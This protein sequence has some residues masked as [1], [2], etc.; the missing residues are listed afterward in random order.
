[1]RLLPRLGDETHKDPSRTTSYGSTI[2]VASSKNVH[3]NN[4]YRDGD[5]DEETDTPFSFLAA[6]GSS[7]QKP[8]LER[9]DSN[10][11]HHSQLST[12]L[13]SV[14]FA[15]ETEI[16]TSNRGAAGSLVSVTQQQQ[17]IPLVGGATVLSEVINITKNLLGAGVLSLSG[18][19]ALFTDQSLTAVT[20]GTLWIM[21]QAAMFGYFAIVI[22]KVCHMTDSRT[23]RECWERTL[24]RDYAVAIVV[25]IG[26]NPC[27]G[28]LAYSAILSQ[29]FQSLCASLGLH[30]SYLKSLFFVTLVALVPLCL[31]K[32]IHALAP[33][34][35]LGTASV[36]LTAVGMVWR[37]VDGT[38]RAPDGLYYQDLSDEMR[39][40]FG[41]R[42]EMGSYKIMPFLCMIFEAYVMHY[43]SP[44]FYMELRDR[45]IGRFAKC[46]GGSFGLSAFIY[47]TIALAGFL[48]FGSNSDNY[49]LNNYSPRDPVATAC[50][51]L[52]GISVLTI[53]PIAF[54]GFRDSILDAFEVPIEHQTPRYLNNL[55]LIMLSLITLTATFVTDLGMINAV[56]GGTIAVA[57]VAI[58]PYLMFQKAVAQQQQ[59]QQEKQLL[60]TRQEGTVKNKPPKNGHDVRLTSPKMNASPM[61]EVRIAFVLM[62]LAIGIGLGGVATELFMGIA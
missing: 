31:M 26:L 59:Q 48:T 46:I 49:I 21:L 43:N 3:Q 20:T 39:P 41:T 4:N 51:I 29:T 42:Q 45:S 57:M 61:W 8:F 27:Q 2:N 44:R 32:N 17:H 35:V 10:S 53:Y 37:C 23:I 40:H 25:V 30:L 56:G 50:R 13:E 28:T 12:L 60:L 24:G 7:Q 47:L 54:I 9:M 19:M 34:S 38:Y 5:G 22:A 18:G 33:F 14:K 15:H 11:T 55:T 1:M 62:L 16:T 36:V 52:I 58:F 6:Q